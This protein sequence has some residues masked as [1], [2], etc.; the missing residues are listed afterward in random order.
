VKLCAGNG[1]ITNVNISVQN[2]GTLDSISGEFELVMDCLV[3]Q[4]FCIF[5]EYM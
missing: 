4:F 5:F 1:I 2:T 3:F